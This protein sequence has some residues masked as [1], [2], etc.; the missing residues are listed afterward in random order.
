MIDLIDLLDGV[1]LDGEIQ[2]GTQVVGAIP[3]AATSPIQ[4][5]EGQIAVVR[6]LCARSHRLPGTFDLAEVATRISPHLVMER[7]LEEAWTALS[8]LL[9]AGSPL[10][11]NVVAS[12]SP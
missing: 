3:R 9:T 6:S 10:T 12:G 5:L 1:E 4:A 11:C 2:T 8:D 7:N